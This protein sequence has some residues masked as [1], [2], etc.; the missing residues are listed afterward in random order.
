MK[1]AAS[2]LKEQ[3]RDSSNFRKRAVLVGT[4]STNRYGW[5]RWVFDQFEL[6]EARSILELGCGPGTLWKQ[7]L[8]RTPDAAQVVLSDF[9]AGMLRDCVRNLREHASRFRFC[10]LDG[11]RLPFRRR[12]L[13]I[14]IANM[15]L[16][17]LIDRSGALRDIL[18][19]LA[20]RG[21][22][23]ATT[24]GRNFMRELQDTT[25]Q[26][27]GSPGR[28]ASAELFGLET[29][30]EQLKDVFGHVE[31]RRYEN[32]LRVTNVQPLMDYFLSM[33]PFLSAPPE[34]WSALRQHFETI[35]DEGGEIFIPI[36]MGMLI[37]WN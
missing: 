1:D 10:R 4:F 33:T 16:Y 3:Y 15:M 21:V 35:I 22:F 28:P 29:G 7:N 12:S 20:P 13:D 17:H 24:T 30:Y 8:D 31:I 5:Y 25:Y 34:R 27:L 18:S 32:S 9:S 2:V 6:A 19:T 23:Y 14:V 11:A 26:I 37:A 36:D